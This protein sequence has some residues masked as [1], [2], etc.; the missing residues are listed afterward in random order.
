MNEVPI[1]HSINAYFEGENTNTN[2]ELNRSRYRSR[3]GSTHAVNTS[4]YNTAS[5]A[6]KYNMGGSNINILTPSRHE[7]TNKKRNPKKIEIPE[8]Y[9]STLEDLKADRC[10]VIDFNGAELGDQNVLA[11]VEYI[12][13]S[14]KLR[15]L[16]LVR[17]KLSD[18]CIQ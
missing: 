15:N 2:A 6:R 9:R 5:N 11:L 14:K 18:E 10:E 8:K 12:E 17:N 13:K 1:T 3:C 16:K 7:N 4:S